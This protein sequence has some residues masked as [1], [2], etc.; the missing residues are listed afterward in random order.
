[1]VSSF[2]FSCEIV[3]VGVMRRSVA[4]DD[5]LSAAA[6]D[7]G[8]EIKTETSFGVCWN[9]IIVNR[10]EECRGYGSFRIRSDERQDR[11]RSIGRY[12]QGNSCEL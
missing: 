1:M 9:D 8:V 11:G 7:V 5:V 12:A 4:K 6:P 3:H 10:Q 2:A